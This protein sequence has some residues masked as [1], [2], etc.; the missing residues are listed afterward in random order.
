METMEVDRHSVGR[1]LTM[2]TMDLNKRISKIL[3]RILT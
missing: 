1:F 2:E 3:L